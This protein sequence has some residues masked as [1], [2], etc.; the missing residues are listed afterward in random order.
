MKQLHLPCSYCG[1]WTSPQP[2]STQQVEGVLVT[3]LHVRTACV[4]CMGG[5]LTRSASLCRHAMGLLLHHQGPAPQPAAALQVWSRS[6]A[7]L[8]CA[9]SLASSNASAS[10][11]MAPLTMGACSAQH[12][13]VEH[14]FQLAAALQVQAAGV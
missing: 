9:A 12:S 4:L 6:S 3:V 11:V 13:A 8:I 5:W 2:C 10:R 1:R 7:T 14:R